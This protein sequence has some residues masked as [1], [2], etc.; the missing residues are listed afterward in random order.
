MYD[1]AP[2]VTSF[3]FAA[4]RPLGTQS[5][6]VLRI[7]PGGVGTQPSKIT[8]PHNNKVHSHK[9]MGCLALHRLERIHTYYVVGSEVI[10]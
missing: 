1:I 10:R 4:V 3:I 2:L 5:L 6:R 8:S 9:K 7:P